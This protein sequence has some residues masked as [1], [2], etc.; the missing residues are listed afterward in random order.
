MEDMFEAGPVTM[1]DGRP[2]LDRLNHIGAKYGM[3]Y[4]T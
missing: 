2:D 4:R 3:E 1:K